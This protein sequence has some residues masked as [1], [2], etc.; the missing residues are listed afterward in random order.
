MKFSVY[1]DDALY[2]AACDVARPMLGPDAGGSRLVQHALK[3]LLEPSGRPGYVAAVEDEAVAEALDR[4]ASRLL[5]QARNN[6]QSG[7]RAG[8]VEAERISWDDLEALALL[9][10]DYDRY[11]NWKVD[12]LSE[13]LGD[14][15]SK[16]LYDLAEWRDHVQ[17]E[18]GTA[19]REGFVGALR[20]VHTRVV[21]GPHDITTDV[22]D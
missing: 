3:A 22:E 12:R 6:F 4:Q 18:S 9:G 10:W 14:D 17:L 15:E 8:V 13:A 1:V 16:E 20:E 5:Q 19:Y 11:A 21:R 7:W 2:E